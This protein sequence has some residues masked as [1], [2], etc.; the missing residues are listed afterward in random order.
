MNTAWLR[1]CEN[2]NGEWDNVDL[3]LDDNDALCYDSID[4]S[5]FDKAMLDYL[6]TKLEE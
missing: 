1:M 4:W 3:K 2:D 5:E 6:A